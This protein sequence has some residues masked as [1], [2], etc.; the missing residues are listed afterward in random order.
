MN[1]MKEF[2]SIRIIVDKDDHLGYICYDDASRF[3][4]K[5]QNRMIMAGVVGT[6]MARSGLKWHK[7]LDDF[8]YSTQ[9][10]VQ[11]ELSLLGKVYTGVYN[12]KKIK[13]MLVD[14]HVVFRSMHDCA[15]TSY[16]VSVLDGTGESERLIKGIPASSIDLYIDRGFGSKRD[17]WHHEMSVKGSIA[18]EFIKLPIFRDQGSSKLFVLRS[19]M[20]SFVQE[21]DELYT[22]MGVDSRIGI[23]KWGTSINDLCKWGISELAGSELLPSG[24]KCPLTYSA[25]IDGRM[26]K[27][28]IA[29][30]D[31]VFR[32]YN[33]CFVS[34]VYVNDTDG[35]LYG[36]IPSS[37][38]EKY[39]MID[40]NIQGN[41][42][43][44]SMLCDLHN[45]QC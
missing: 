4:S 39:L 10:I 15:V 13:M 41:K 8:A 43:D 16:S 36:P 44:N 34:S 27:V 17:L 7:M 9:F 12:G 26:S 32:K 21:V 11:E 22:S 19:D 14:A 24:G 28:Q 1:I 33:V 37:A 25:V 38:V 31:V 29:S 5:I 23:L 42:H 35:S 30:T 3:I 45:L 40:R 2:D 18:A 6:D 20:Y